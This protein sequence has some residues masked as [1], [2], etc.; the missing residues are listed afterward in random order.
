[1]VNIYRNVVFGNTLIKDDRRLIFTD[2]LIL[3]SSCE[4]DIS[5]RREYTL[6]AVV[7]HYGSTLSG[8]YTAHVEFSDTW[9]FCNDNLV[10]K[11]SLSTC[12][13]ST[14]SSLFLSV[15]EHNIFYPPTTSV[16]V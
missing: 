14:V 11:C 8:H 16:S 1:M 9:F 10:S 2:K 5:I 7:N 6:G 12:N 3:T 4:D 15:P 13:P